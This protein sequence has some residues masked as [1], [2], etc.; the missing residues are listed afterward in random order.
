MAFVGGG[1][2]VLI[3]VLDGK[4]VPGKP[5]LM[6]Y[7]TLELSLQSIKGAWTSGRP[8]VELEI[9]EGDYQQKCMV[10]RSILTILD[11]YGLG[12]R[13]YEIPFGEQYV[14]NPQLDT[15]EITAKLLGSILDEADKEVERQLHI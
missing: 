7:K 9:F 10:L 4:P 11:E 12:A 8:V 6:L 14:D 15:Y 13:F 1:M 3:I 5:L 2:S